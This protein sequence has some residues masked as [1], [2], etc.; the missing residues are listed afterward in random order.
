M[1]GPKSHFGKK[2]KTPPSFIFINKK[3]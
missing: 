2:K 3:F 1:S